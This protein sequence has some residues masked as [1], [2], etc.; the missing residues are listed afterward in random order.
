[1]GP[2]LVTGAACFGAAVGIGLITA[3]ASR[4]LAETA[5][6]LAVRGLHVIL[7]AFLEG[8]GVLGVVIGLLAI[9]AAGVGDT[10]SAIVAAVPAV[11][12]AIAGLILARGADQGSIRPQRVGLPFIGGLGVL[13]IVVGVEAVLIGDGRAIGGGDGPFAIVAVVLLATAIGGAVSGARGLGAIGLARSSGPSG[14]GV[15]GTL[16]YERMQV[17]RRAA[18]VQSIAI[19]AAVVAIALIV[20][21]AP[22]AV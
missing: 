4:A 1:M 22:K 9:M 20:A 18:V 10:S 3:A 21:G 5:E 7:I 6:P 2:L 8:I 11:G 19:V 16:E 13:G 17:I 12:G 14:I 15:P